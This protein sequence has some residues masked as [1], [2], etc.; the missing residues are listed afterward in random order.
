MRI[1]G[2]IEL[3]FKNIGPMRCFYIFYRDTW[4]KYGT[5]GIANLVTYAALFRFIIFSSYPL[6]F[7]KF[8]QK[9][10]L[11]LK[12]IYIFRYL[13][14]LIV[15]Y[16]PVYFHN[17]VEWTKYRKSSAHKCTVCTCCAKRK[18][19]WKTAGSRNL[20]CTM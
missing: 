2:Y 4:C 1:T 7:N 8:S 17:S 14:F 13:F 9:Y 18:C 16:I 10:L 19:C 11:L 5:N 12:N 6:V 15:I 3:V 20:F